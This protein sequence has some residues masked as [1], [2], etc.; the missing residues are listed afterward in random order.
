MTCSQDRQRA[1]GVLR[2]D[3]GDHP[4]T[5]VERLLHLGAVDASPLLDQPEYRCGSP[6]SAIEFGNQAVRDNPLRVSPARPPPVT[7]QKVQDRRFG[8]QRQAVL[9]VDAGGFEQFLAESAAELLDMTGE[10]HPVDVEQDLGG[11]ASNRWSA[12]PMT[13]S[14]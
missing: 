3:D 1:V 9:G 13:P 5:H 4:D 2:R 11:P 10:I 14:R 6:R 12:D 8:G 7:W